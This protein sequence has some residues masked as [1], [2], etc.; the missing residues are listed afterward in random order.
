MEVI[1]SYV[2]FKFLTVVDTKRPIFW[3]NTS[4]I[5]LKIKGLFGGMSPLLAILFTLVSCLAYSSTP[6]MEM[7]RPSETSVDFQRTTWRYV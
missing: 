1:K 5:P 3:D 2:G 7:T 6:K 4:C